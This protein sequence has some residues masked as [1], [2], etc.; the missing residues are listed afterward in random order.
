[1][2][3]V[4][5]AVRRTENET[6][7]SEMMGALVLIA[8]IAAAIGIVGVGFLSQPPPQKIP[9]VSVDITAIGN[10]VYIRHDGGDPLT[11]S[12]FNITLD[13]IDKTDS[14]SVLNG[15]A[16]WS[17]W[18]P[19]ETLYYI[20]PSGQS[21]PTLVQIIYNSGIRASLGSYSPKIITVP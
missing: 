19:G 4:D 8:V 1:M 2:V 9:A 11:K 3:W 5:N 15:P 6:G 14:F 13:G 20:V 12:D 10:I 17:T 16:S 18:I 7:V 21:V